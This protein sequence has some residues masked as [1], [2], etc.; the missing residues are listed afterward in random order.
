[1][2]QF[3]RVKD[4]CRITTLCKSALYERVRKGEFIKPIK[5]GA[6]ASFWAA[7]EVEAFQRAVMAGAPPEH[8]RALVRELEAARKECA[9]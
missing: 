3:L 6:R 1:M 2:I 7:S 9:A 8:L 4:V 5:L